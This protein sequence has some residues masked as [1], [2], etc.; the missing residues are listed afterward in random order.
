[1]SHAN[2]VSNFTYFVPSFTSNG[3][4]SLLNNNFSSAKSDWKQTSGMRVSLSQTLLKVSGSSSFTIIRRK[5]TE[6]AAFCIS[7]TQQ[8]VLSFVWALKHHSEGTDPEWLL[9]CAPYLPS[10]QVWNSICFCYLMVSGRTVSTDQ[11]GGR[12]GKRD[13]EGKNCL[14]TKVTQGHETNRLPLGLVLVVWKIT[15]P[16]ILF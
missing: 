14:C 10:M 11:K 12:K 4:K 9:G 1:M 2:L 3:E 7:Q 8:S 16:F 5:L 13:S 15:Y 6:L